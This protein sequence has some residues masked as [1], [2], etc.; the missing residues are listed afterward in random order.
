[1]W[2]EQ[3]RDG[4]KS[5]PHPGRIPALSKEDRGRLAELLEEGAVAQ[6]YSNELWTLPRVAA[7]IKKSLTPPDFV[8]DAR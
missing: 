2:E 5:K 4:L 8:V 6:G 1:M 3:G 7:L